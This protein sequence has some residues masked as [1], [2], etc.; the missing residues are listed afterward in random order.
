[1][2]RE[3]AI[4]L[5]DDLDN[6]DKEVTEWEADFIDSLLKNTDDLFWAPPDSQAAVLIRMKEA[7][8]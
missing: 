1:L 4:N 5:L 7:Y 6:C 2:N 8:L 3:R